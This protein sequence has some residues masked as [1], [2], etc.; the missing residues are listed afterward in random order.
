MPTSF[1]TDVTV[2]N[3]DRGEFISEA[4]ARLA[5][6]L[7]DYDRYFSLVYIPSKDRTSEDIKPFAILHSPPGVSPYI[8]RYLSEHE[9][10]RPQEVL[11]WVFENDTNRSD[12]LGRLE[13]ADLARK[14]YNAAQEYDQRQEELDKLRFIA[15]TPLNKFKIGNTEYRK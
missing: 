15:N 4:H 10:S 12:V 9:M 8:A 14:V 13:A 5:D 11:A 7:A 1:G 6:I 2:W 3:S